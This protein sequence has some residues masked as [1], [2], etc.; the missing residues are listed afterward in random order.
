MG[1]I[2][3]PLISI[4]TVSYNAVNTIEETILS[5]VNQN[6]ED[7]EY[8]II[9]GGSTDGTLD[10]IKK[11]QDK[12]THWVSE[13]DK[14]IYDAMNKGI[15]LASGEWINFM[16]S[17]DYFHRNDT[18]SQVVSYF[19][20]E[21]N[22]IY[23]NTL[24]SYERNKTSKYLT[25]KKFQ[26]IRY[27]IPFCHQSVFVKSELIKEMKF[28]LMYRYSAD[29]DFFLKIYKKK[30]YIY[31]KVPIP[32]SIYDMNGVSNGLIT[33]KENYL[34][35]KKYY[36]FSWISMYHFYIFSKSIVKTKI[37]SK[38]PINLVN[39]LLHFKKT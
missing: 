21:L 13:P 9:D 12:I 6:F 1:N 5:V 24:L 31:K 3:T 11:H 22:I 37:K 20:I 29:Y 10:V 19:S 38:L 33:L 16:N 27:S 32:I 7:Y 36:P 4:I 28:D 30:K 25:A 35:A 23:G 39:I 15:D 2:K 14:G 18:V 17:G 8:I 26:N 34:I